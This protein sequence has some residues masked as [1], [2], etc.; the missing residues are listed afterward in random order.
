MEQLLCRVVMMATEDE[1]ARV[2][3]YT[4]GKLAYNSDILA[5]HTNQHLYFTSER[6]ILP[7]DWCLFFDSFDNLWTDRPLQ[8]DP[9]QGHVLNKG[10]RKVEATTNRDLIL[11]LVP[12]SF[13]ENYV[14][15]NGGIKEVNIEM[16]E[17]LSG[18][19]REVMLSRGQVVGYPSPKT[20]VDNSVIISDVLFFKN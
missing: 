19:F 3:R 14:R 12:Q 1:N 16:G 2:C 17:T 10:L 4:N 20:G 15:E 13:I 5:Y 11:P 7:G 9:Q 6:D 8:Y 18:D